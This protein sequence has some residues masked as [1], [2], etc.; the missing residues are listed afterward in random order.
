MCK[1]CEISAISTLS[2]KKNDA[3]C[4]L[5]LDI[6]DSLSNTVNKPANISNRPKSIEAVLKNYCQWGNLS[7]GNEFYCATC[8]EHKPPSRKTEILYGP[9]IIVMQQNRFT[10]TKANQ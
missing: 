10:I 2:T 5:S 7:T 4:I 1:K 9:E 8:G 6:E 3:I